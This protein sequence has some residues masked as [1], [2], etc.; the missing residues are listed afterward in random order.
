M[1]KTENDKKKSFFFVND[2]SRYTKIYCSSITADNDTEIEMWRKQAAH[3][4]A[5][6]HTNYKIQQWIIF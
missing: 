2:S 3:T 1:P 6:R 4:L 5:P